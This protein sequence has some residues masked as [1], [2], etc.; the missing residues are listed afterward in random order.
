MKKLFEKF[1]WTLIK[2]KELKSEHIKFAS[3]NKDKAFE[4]FE[5]HSNT[6]FNC[7]W[8]VQEWQ[9]EKYEILKTKIK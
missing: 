8:S 5:K 6:G 3:T 7:G 1:G 4:Y 2:S 9:G